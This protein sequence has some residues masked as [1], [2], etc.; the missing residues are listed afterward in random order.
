V[1]KISPP[2]GVSETLPLLLLQEPDG[3]A[4]LKVVV[5]P[6]HIVVVPVM[7]L[8]V[9]NGLTVNGEAL[10]AVPPGVVTDI[11]PVVAAVGTVAVICVALLTANVAAVPLMFT[12]VAPVK[13]VPVMTTE[14]PAQIGDGEKLVTVGGGEKTACTWKLSS[15]TLPEP[16]FEIVNLIAKEVVGLLAPAGNEMVPL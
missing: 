2:E 13:F 15:C 10:V 12:A 6:R 11:V 1:T 3:V 4:L 5:P 16:L 9:G 14:E 8:T 7:G